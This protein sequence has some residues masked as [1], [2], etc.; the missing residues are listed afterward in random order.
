MRIPSFV[1]SW[2]D[3]LT[4]RIPVPVI[5]GVNRGRWWSLVSAGSGYVTG[6]RAHEQM[7]VLRQ[8]ISPGDIVWDVGAHHGCVTLLAAA[9]VQ[10]D[11]WV[12]TFEP[13]RQNLRILKRNI[14]WNRLHNVSVQECA[15]ASYTGTARFGGG[16]TSKMHMLGSGEEEVAVCTGETLVRSGA[17]RAPTFVKIDVEG[18]EGDVLAGALPILPSR[19]VMLVA[20]HSAT[21]DQQC[22]CLLQANGFELLPSRALNR[23]RRFGW[24]GDPDLLC[25]GPD[26]HD[27][28][29]ITRLPQT[30]YFQ[31]EGVA[32]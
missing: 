11:G 4:E 7:A 20:I 25:I 3:P 5:A 15:L 14:R 26:H 30:G 19:A 9:Q 2:L 27:G 28:G 21:T 29:R 31:K 32:G 16:A 6:R 8:L 23:A 22:T 1:R 24:R 18:A 10:P 12:Y 17:V 13:G